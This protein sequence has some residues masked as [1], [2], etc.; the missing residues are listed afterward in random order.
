MIAALSAS[1]CSWCPGSLALDIISIVRASC[2][3][4]L[5]TLFCKALDRIDLAH[6]RV[7]A[8]AVCLWG[9]IETPSTSYI[10]EDM[11]GSVRCRVPGA[12]PARLS[13]QPPSRCVS[14]KGMPVGCLESPAT[15]A[16]CLRCLSLTICQAFCADTDVCRKGRCSEHKHL[17]E[18]GFICSAGIIFHGYGRWH[19]VA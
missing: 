15:Y 1:T 12:G 13:F 11:C 4:Q 8:L 10:W 7:R 17:A 2:S 3:W 19:R 9:S 5:Y 6:A 18:A 14:E 16:V